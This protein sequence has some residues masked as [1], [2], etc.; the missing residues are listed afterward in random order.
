[1]EGQEKAPAVQCGE[2]SEC[3]ETHRDVL[4]GLST[5]EALS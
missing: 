4:R 1:M 2:L 3:L 5:V